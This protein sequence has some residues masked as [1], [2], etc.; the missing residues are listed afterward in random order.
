MSPKQLTDLQ[1]TPKKKITAGR[2]LIC[3][4]WWKPIEPSILDQRGVAARLSL[5]STEPKP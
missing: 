5:R 4:Q 3:Q 1:L 2:F